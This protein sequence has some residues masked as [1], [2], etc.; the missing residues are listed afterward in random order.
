VG[1]ILGY[2]PSSARE[3]ALANAITLNAM[4]YL[5]RGRSSFHPVQDSVSYNDQKEEGDKASLEWTT[6]KM[7]IWL[8]HFEKVVKKHGANAPASGGSSITYAD[9]ALFHILD[10]T[11]A[12]FNSEKYE[13][14]WDKQN[15]P[16]LKEY[17]LWM[18]SRPNLK[19]Y[20]DSERVSRKS[21]KVNATAVSVVST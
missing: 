2:S 15:V 7:P 14:A 17:H 21:N 11:I 6:E 1:D 16:A 3:K 12:Q 20:F 18:K 9:F 13:M 4:D 5:A 8:A 19:A 10:A